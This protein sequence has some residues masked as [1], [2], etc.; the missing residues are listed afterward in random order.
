M[1]NKAMIQDVR[2]CKKEEIELESVQVSQ[3]PRPLVDF[4]H[5]DDH[6]SQVPEPD[7]TYPGRNVI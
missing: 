5:S 3:S 1:D 2:F 4:T 7:S 6:I